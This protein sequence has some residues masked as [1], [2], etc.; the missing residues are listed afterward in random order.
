MDFLS[1][2][3]RNRGPC[4]LHLL[5]GDEAWWRIY[6]V[7]SPWLPPGRGPA[8]RHGQ[9]WRGGNRAFFRDRSSGCSAGSL[10]R[11]DRTATSRDDQRA[12]RG[13]V[14]RA[15]ARTCHPRPLA[16]R[17]NSL[18]HRGPRALPSSFRCL[19]AGPRVGRRIPAPG[20]VRTLSR[21]S[22]QSPKPSES[23]WRHLLKTR[24][25]FKSSCV[26]WQSN[27]LHSSPLLQPAT[28]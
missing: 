21:P 26:A 5:C 16:F 25:P 7:P 17:G 27:W 14:F 22:A 8:G 10:R 4:D 24:P 13:L 19:A 18:L 3:V 1:L 23:P 2:P 15:G 6:V 11:V 9:R 28:P 20:Q 12:P